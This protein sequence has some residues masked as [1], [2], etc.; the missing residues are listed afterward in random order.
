MGL[1]RR[2]GYRIREGERIGG[3]VRGWRVERIE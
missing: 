3:R 2:G 1:E